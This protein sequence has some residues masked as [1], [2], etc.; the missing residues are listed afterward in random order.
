MTEAAINNW[1]E[2]IQGFNGGRLTGTQRFLA[3]AAFSEGIITEE[4]RDE[5][6]LDE[7]AYCS[8]LVAYRKLMAQAFMRSRD[9]RRG[10]PPKNLIRVDFVRRVSLGSCRDFRTARV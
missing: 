3:S 2:A 10:T 6:W 7:Q 1:I 5:V 4:E 8:V 9:R